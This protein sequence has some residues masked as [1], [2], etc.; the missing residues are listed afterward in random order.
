MPKKAK[1]EAEPEAQSV[2]TLQPLLEVMITLIGRLVYPPEKIMEI[3]K[4]KKRNPEQYVAIYNLCDGE[5]T[6]SEIAKTFDQDQSGLSRILSDWKDLGIVYEITKKGGKFYKKLYTLEEPKQS[7][8]PK[9]TKS[10]TKSTEPQGELTP[11][12]VQPEVQQ[13]HSQA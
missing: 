6:G 11:S 7:E 1:T 12:T 3:V 8:T 2:E 5:H 10:E 13:A 9:E 4:F